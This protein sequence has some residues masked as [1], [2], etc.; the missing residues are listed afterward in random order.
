MCLGLQRIATVAFLRRVQIFLLTY[1]LAVHCTLDLG[2]QLA[3]TWHESPDAYCT[4]MMPLQSATKEECPLCTLRHGQPSLQPQTVC[5]RNVQCM[6]PKRPY[7]GS[8]HLAWSTRWRQR[9]WQCL[10][11]SN[12]QTI[13]STWCMARLY[14][15]EPRIITRAS[16]SLYHNIHPTKSFELQRQHARCARRLPRHDQLPLLVFSHT[17]MCC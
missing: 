13:S 7:S 3:I 8:L 12:A 16:C 15:T 6:S 14:T 10:W 5:W 1:L 9:R 17:E 2:M 11:S 4:E